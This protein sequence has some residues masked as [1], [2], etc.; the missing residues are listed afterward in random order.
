MIGNL[1]KFMQKTSA[2]GFGNLLEA[3]KGKQR[4]FWA[5]LCACKQ[6]PV[7]I[8]HHHLS[9]R[10]SKKFELLQMVIFVA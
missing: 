3:S 4:L 10:M 5:I 7:K 1:E 8:L 6:R 2:H 9:G